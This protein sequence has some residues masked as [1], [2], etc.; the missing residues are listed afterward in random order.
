[1]KKLLLLMACG[2]LVGCEYTVPLVKTPSMNTDPALV[3]LWQRTKPDGQVESL[4]VLPLGAQ[5]YLVSF[6][7][8]SKDSMFARA[9]LCRVAERTLMQLEWI[10][11]GRGKTVE[12]G[13]AFQFATYVVTGNT[14]SIRMLNSSV[15][16]KD[17][18][19]S[20]ELAAAIVANKDKPNLFNE[21]MIFNKVKE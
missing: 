17:V 2:I 21:E 13:R 6:P 9:C 15:V 20:Q 7:A 18:K 12:D 8:G 10:G 3:G 4:V 19:T 14:V 5:E 1:M 16:S 11:N